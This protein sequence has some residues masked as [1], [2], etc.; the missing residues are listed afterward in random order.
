[1]GKIPCYPNHIFPGLAFD[2]E[3]RDLLLCDHD[4][5]TGS[6]HDTLDQFLSELS[7]KNRSSLTIRCYGIDC[8]PF[9]SWLSD[10]DLMVVSPAAITKAHLAEYLAS[11]SQRGLSGRTRARK[12]A[13]IKEYFRFLVAAGLIPVSPAETMTAPRSFHDQD[14]YPSPRDRCHAGPRAGCVRCPDLPPRSGLALKHPDPAGIRDHR[15]TPDHRRDDRRGA[16][17]AP[18]RRE[19]LRCV[20]F[21]RKAWAWW[22]VLA[23]HVVALG[24]VLL[25]IGAIAAGLGP[26]TDLNDIYHRVMVVVLVAGLVLLLTP[27]AK[28]ALGRGNRNARRG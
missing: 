18:L 2:Q 20:H 4:T 12:L 24:D 10:T 9:L 27:S 11:L 21:T 25:G 7:G 13:A 1:M 5:S 8:T 23:A 16:Q 6:L 3:R 15:G 26:R 14:H 17:R 28:A 22:V 19:R